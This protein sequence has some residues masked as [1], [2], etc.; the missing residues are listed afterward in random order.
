MKTVISIPVLRNSL[1]AYETR[2]VK[3]ANLLAQCEQIIKYAWKGLT[4][5][6]SVLTLAANST[7][8]SNGSLSKEIQNLSLIRNPFTNKQEPIDVARY[9]SQSMTQEMHKQNSTDF[10]RS[11]SVT[12]N[13]NIS[14]AQQKT[15]SKNI[16]NMYSEAL[17]LVTLSQVTIDTS[18]PSNLTPNQ[19][20]KIINLKI[21]RTPKPIEI[22]QRANEA[23]DDHLT[24]KLLR[25]IT[26]NSSLKMLPT[27]K[28]VMKK[29][30]VK[31]IVNRNPPTHNLPELTIQSFVLPDPPDSNRN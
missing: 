1:N 30:K 12:Q 24:K 27:P 10:K 13:K 21:S 25:I 2:G 3:Y 17:N 8:R 5:P 20:A 29:I 19:S 9:L 23:I 11:M 14:Y 26:N 28:S 15:L 6:K 31:Y 7:I 4:I 22:Y 16:R 18:N